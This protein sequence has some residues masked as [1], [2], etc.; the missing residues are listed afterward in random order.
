MQWADPSLRARLTPEVRLHLLRQA[1]ARR[2]DSPSQLLELG[3]VLLSINQFAEAAAAFRA[4]AELAPSGAAF[5]GLGSA[6]LALD[7]VRAAADAYSR[8]VDCAPASTGALLGRARALRRL[9]DSEGALSTALTACEGVP[10]SSGVLEFVASALIAAGRAVE[11]LAITDRSLASDPRS[12]A[13]RFHR[14]VALAALG[15]RADASAI[16]NPQL[17][18]IV[19]VAPPA[20][21]PSFNA[22]L[23]SEILANESLV[24]APFGNAA[25]QAYRARALLAGSP[26]ALT[27]LMAIARAEFDRYAS[28]HEGSGGAATLAVPPER[29]RL[30]TWATVF[31]SEGHEAQHIHPRSWI[32]GVYYVAAPEAAAAPGRQGTLLVP[33]TARQD[34]VDGDDWPVLE[35]APQPGRM[36]IFPSYFPHR[37][38]PTGSDEPRISVAFDVVPAPAGSEADDT[39]S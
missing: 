24:Y 13:A 27:A 39:P 37:T 34:A 4:A 26:P 8:A 29:V 17:V 38:V 23:R 32:S 33:A 3:G 19:D 9:G 31:G 2:P 20:A 21:F 10:I 35:I 25:R 22:S 16:M 18:R 11:L 6:L 12:T 14:A 28:L 36:V 30:D 15:H 7:D 1:V 5:A